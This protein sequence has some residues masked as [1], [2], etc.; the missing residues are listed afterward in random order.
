MRRYGVYINGMSC[1]VS[2]FLI[3]KLRSSEFRRRRKKHLKYVS[4]VAINNH[5][6]YKDIKSFS[7]E[8]KKSQKVAHR[9][10]KVVGDR[11]CQ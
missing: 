8:D 7:I 9:D 5:C 10:N 11:N 4:A 6:D 3:L 1:A 2:L